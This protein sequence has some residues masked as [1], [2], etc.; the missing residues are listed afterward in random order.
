VK[1]FDAV[2]AAIRS[3]GVVPSAHG[4]PRWYVYRASKVIGGQIPPDALVF[5][6]KEKAQVRCDTLNA[7]A[8]IE[9]WRYG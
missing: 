3:Y 1:N 2:V 7:E 4:F 9:M 8:V 5:F 6:S